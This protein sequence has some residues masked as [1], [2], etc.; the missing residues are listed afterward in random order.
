MPKRLRII[1]LFGLVALVASPILT[2]QEEQACSPE[3]RRGDV[4]E[5]IHGVELADPY[6]WLEEQQSDETRAWIEAQNAYTESLL[7][8]LPYLDGLRERLTE[9]I[10]IDAVG[11]PFAR[12]DRYFLAKRD[13]DQDLFVIYMREG[14]DGEDQVLIDP[15]PMSEDHS[16]SVNM[17]DVSE[18]GTLMLY[19]VR[20][21]GMDEVSVRAYD[22]D[23]RADL[24]DALPGS[25]YFGFSILPDNSGFIYTRFSMIG[26]RVFLHRMGTEWTEDRMLFGDGYGPDKIVFASLSEEGDWLVVHVLYGSAAQK[27]EIYIK[28]LAEDGEFITVVN[29][30]DGRFFGGILEDHLVLQT[31]WEAPN[32]RV[33]ITEVE[34]PTSEHWLELI[35][36]REDAVLQ[37]VTGV[38]GRIFVN[39]LRNVRSSIVC[40]DREGGSLGEISF[41]TIGTVSNIIGDW[42]RSEAFFVFTSFHVPTTIYRY[43]VESG[44]REVWYQ[45]D[46]PIDPE[47]FEI[48]QV[49]YESADGTRVPMFLVHRRDIE[50]DG[51]NPTFLT[52][53]GGFGA[54]STPGY[55]STAAL[56]VESGGVFA[57][58]NL[59]GGGEF[60]EE[61][62][63]AGM[64][65]NKQNVFD[66]FIAAAEWLIANGYTR[67]GRLAIRGG[68]NGGL[69]VGAAVTQRPDLFG[70]V[71]CTYPL[72]DMVRYHQFMV[73]PFWVPEYG[74]AADPEQFPFLLEYSPYHNVERGT[75]YPAVL[76][77]TGDGDTRVAPLHARKMAALMQWATG[78]E[79]PILLRY[80]TQAGHS[81]GLPVTR[82]IEEAALGFGF[83]F[84]QLGVTPQ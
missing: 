22:V 31:N 43:D 20:E 19:G 71:V 32:G 38:G 24:P 48:S 46:V 23:A 81:G 25:R 82:Q 29:D 34:N 18:D 55:S 16:T 65:G 2:A 58:P 17:L 59:R 30:I 42:D 69:L 37:S 11:V 12:G 57:I 6:R 4:V 3:T 1:F 74:S 64:L 21:G 53:Y 8:Q 49:W 33:L 72:L 9:L 75:E 44:E 61:W 66:D 26:P 10:R 47:V 41:E 15:H 45:L 84:W 63:R 83:I 7:G 67:P 60:G 13:A 54:S 39:Y 52:G 28:N 62:H 27:T 76:F 70:A 73:A 50:L 40:F 5:T 35:P 80:D 36:E 14:L 51:E 68:S 56:W 78:S 77:I 79:R